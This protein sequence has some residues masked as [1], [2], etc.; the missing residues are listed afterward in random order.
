MEGNL[1]KVRTLNGAVKELRAM[2]VNS[3][4]TYNMVKTWCDKG[5][6][7]YICMGNRRLI[8]MDTCIKCINGLFGNSSD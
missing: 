6:L 2:D 3:G 8:D 4:V 1:A 7:P 5:I